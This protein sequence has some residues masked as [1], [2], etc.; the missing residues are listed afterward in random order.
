[1]GVDTV[2]LEFLKRFG[3]AWNRHDVEAVMA[4]MTDDSTFAPSVGADLIAGGC[5]GREAVTAAVRA[6]METWP[7]GH[8][9][10]LGEF[11][12]GNRGVSEWIFSGTKPDGSRLRTRGCDVLTFENGKIKVKDAYRKQLP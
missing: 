1:V 9:E 5:Q 6:F 8:F 7:D 2:S 3:E 11:V 12:A 4:H 10:S